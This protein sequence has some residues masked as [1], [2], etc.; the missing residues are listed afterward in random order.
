MT[1]L[2]KK[3]VVKLGDSSAVTV[4]RIFQDQ[5]TEE[6]FP[7]IDLYSYRKKLREFLEKEIRSLSFLSKTQT[8]RELLSSRRIRYR[9]VSYKLSLPARIFD[10]IS[11]CKLRGKFS[12]E[13]Y[14]FE[15]DMRLEYERKNEFSFGET[16]A[17]E[18]FLYAGEW[19]R[20][21]G[22]PDAIFENLAVEYTITR[23]DINHLLGRCVIYSYMCMKLFTVCSTL[24]IPTTPG[25]E[26]GFMVIPN[27]NALE[28][29]S[30]L[31]EEI[32]TKDVEGKKNKFCNACLYKRICPSW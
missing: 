2:T 23:G 26:I 7:G 6:D 30:D 25:E 16:E 24:I 20:I 5:F 21:A 29:Y 17:L 12:V 13:S 3:F 4:Y 27:S 22:V 19:V 32:I 18:V 8:S 11:V 15:K 1:F 14:K 28:Y 10:D 31:L 9:G